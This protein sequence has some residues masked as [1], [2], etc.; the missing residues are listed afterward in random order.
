MKVLAQ[1][2]VKSVQTGTY[3]YSQAGSQQITIGA[4]GSRAVIITHAYG[5]NSFGVPGFTATL[6]DSTTLEFQR[7]Q[8]STNFTISWQI[9]DYA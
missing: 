9:I 1:R 6:I 4:V 7:G 2:Q 3:I 8:S 5:S